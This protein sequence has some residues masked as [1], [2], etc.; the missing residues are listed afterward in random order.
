M[1]KHASIVISILLASLYSIGLTFHQGYLRTLGIEE[2]QFQL[3]LDG[4]FFQGFFA[5]TD[6]S[7]GAIVWLVMAASGVVIVA[8][9]GMLMIEV[10]NKLNLKSIFQPNYFQKAKIIPTTH[11]LS[12]HFECSYIS[13]FYL[14][15]I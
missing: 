8:N 4:L 10:I 15:S 13:S 6:L 2:T 5:T 1:L 3:S 12:F 9:L 14:G 11:F 7:T